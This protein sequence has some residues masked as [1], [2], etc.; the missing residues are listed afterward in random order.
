MPIGR[1]RRSWGLRFVC[2]RPVERNGR[3]LLMQPGGRD[4]I[5][6]QRFEGDHTQHLGEIGGK[7]RIEDVT[8]SIII[9]ARRV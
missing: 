7:Q 5:D 4:R 8:Q 2:I 9:R 1:A 3:R 6:C